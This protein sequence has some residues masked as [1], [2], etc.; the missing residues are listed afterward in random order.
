MPVCPSTANMVDVEGTFVHDDIRIAADT[1]AETSN[2]EI[3]GIVLSDQ[4]SGGK[5][6]VSISVSH[7]SGVSPGESCC[8]TNRKYPG[9]PHGSGRRSLDREGEE[10]TSP[11]ASAS[12]I[13]S[14][15]SSSTSMS[16]P[17]ATDLTIPEAEDLLRTALALPV[18]DV[19]GKRIKAVGKMLVAVDTARESQGKQEETSKSPRLVEE[20]RQAI[21]AWQ[22]GLVVGMDVDARSSR[23]G[24]W[25]AGSLLA[26]KVSTLGAE[27]EE[28]LWEIKFKRFGSSHNELISQTGSSFSRLMPPGS[29]TGRRPIS[30]RLEAEKR[31]R[32][33]ETAARAE[34]KRMREAPTMAPAVLGTTR[35]GRTV[36]S[37]N[38]ARDATGSKKAR[39]KPE[40]K[41]PGPREVAEEGQE[42]GFLVDTGGA[43]QND[44]VCGVCEEMERSEGD[45]LVLCD[46]PCKRSF[47]QACLGMTAEEVRFSETWLCDQC[48]DREHTCFVCG[49][50]G[51]DDGLTDG[52]HKCQKPQCG[53]FYHAHCVS[54]HPNVTIAKHQQ[55]EDDAA[56]AGSLR[57]KFVCPMHI[58]DLCGKGRESGNNRNQLFPCWLC[59]RAY[60]LNC[61]PPACKYHEYLL[62]CPEH[63]EEMDLPRLPGWDEELETKSVVRWEVSA[64]EG[65]ATGG[66]GGGR[67]SIALASLLPP[68]HLPAAFRLPTVLL[69]AVNSKPKPYSHISCLKYQ[70]KV[71]EREPGPECQCEGQCGEGCLNR[72]LHIECVGGGGGGG[73]KEGGED[74][75]GGSGLKGDK[76]EKHHNCNVGPACG[77]RAFRNK[78]YI[79]HQIFR[80]G[81]CG[82]GLRTLENV[83]KGQL[84]FE[85]VGEVIDDDI[86]E[87]RLQEHARER[88]NDHNMYVMELESGYYLDARTK[89]NASRFINHS[90]A[91]NCELQKWNVKGFTRIGIMAITDISAGTPL[92]YD[93]Q[94]ATNEEGKF[95]CHCGAPTCRGTLAP[96]NQLTED[97]TMEALRTGSRTDRK[98]LLQLCK[99]RERRE[100]ARQQQAA[101]ESAA[102]KN[103]TSQFLPG[104]SILEIR[105]GPPTRFLGLAKVNSG[106]L[107]LGTDL[108]P[109]C[110]MTACCTI[111]FCTDTPDLFSLSI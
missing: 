39:P 98:K 27:S 40:K 62:L 73:T 48:R 47:H 15:V 36:R 59:P 7:E 54:Q 34:A 51:K 8:F 87:L 76:K 53:K 33:E 61:I 105:S 93:Y 70:C 91:P 28:R 106:G 29:H 86:L 58:C 92:S 46:G 99:K 10:S 78:E 68:R 64:R 82:W 17:T 108:L 4:A 6:G 110:W 97:Q 67:L 101:K 57:F 45:R 109:S 96:Q 77:N 38:A 107:C 63:S 80:E 23:D 12:E 9:A 2:D 111:D 25:Y 43:D 90:C 52:V 5:N 50:T 83:R 41:A 75:N 88:P 84:V 32:A 21:R 31:R 103:L 94:F 71:P 22:A 16:A 72:L 18:P 66:E 11:E 20:A 42:E 26:E 49:D 44:W 19:K 3:D 37:E 14:T 79:T 30:Q 24:H 35:S 81:G 13:A 56:G 95:K 89:G 60:H 55:G 85:Y 104:D 1:G 74:E 100:Q 65:G 69:D 102:R